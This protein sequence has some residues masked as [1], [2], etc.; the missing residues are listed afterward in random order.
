[1]QLADEMRKGESYHTLLAWYNDNWHK[2]EKS[3]QR[4]RTIIYSQWK[5]EHAKEMQEKKIDL[6]NKIEIDRIFAHDTH[7]AMAAVSADKLVAQIE[8]FLNKQGEGTTTNVQVNNIMNFDH[9]SF[10]EVEKLLN[11]IDSHKDNT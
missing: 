9:L 2:T 11:A 3:F 8:G 7:N 4:D 10:E 6:L 1:M 5:V